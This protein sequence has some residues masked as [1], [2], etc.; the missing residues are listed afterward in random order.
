[1]VEAIDGKERGPDALLLLGKAAAGTGQTA[2]AVQALEKAVEMDPSFVEAWAELAYVHETVKEY[3]K[4]ENIY[5]RMLRMGE[6]GDEVRLRLI[7]LDLKLNDPDK[8][9][10]TAL[11]GSGDTAL[12]LEA[13]RIFLNEGFYDQARRI[14][15]ELEEISPGMDEVAFYRAAAAFEGDQNPEAA[16]EHLKTISEDSPL[17]PRSLGFRIN[18]LHQMGR[19]KEALALIRKANTLFPG[20]R[21]LMLIEAGFY[22]EEGDFGAA[23][24]VLERAAANWPRN[25]EVLY[26]MGVV[27]EKLE[28]RDQ[29]MAV[30]ER[31]IGLDPENTDAL[32]YVGYTLAEQG[33]DLDRAQ[34]LVE[35]ALAQRPDSGFIVDSLAWVHFRKGE[36]DKAWKEIRRA[37]SMVEDAIIWE[38]YGDIARAMGRKAQAKKGYTRAL[39]LEPDNADEIRKKLEEL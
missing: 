5:E 2:K 28:R 8:A 20:D 9:L 30:M 27:L 35:K 12:L 19:K 26:R 22:E 14:L 21:Q 10:T 38:H 17:Y 7:Q 39:K 31:I 24:A 13:A 6:A 23:L 16:L 36:L 32:N 37:V 33:Q 11:E 1:M 3:A 18:L 4:A 34:V 15:T 29:A 25:L